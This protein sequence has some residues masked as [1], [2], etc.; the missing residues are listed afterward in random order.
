MA[1]YFVC[2]SYESTVQHLPTFNDRSRHVVVMEPSRRV[3]ASRRPCSTTQ[4][5]D[6]QCQTAKIFKSFAHPL[7]L[8]CVCCSLWVFQALDLEPLSP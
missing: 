5:P 7:A 4:L 8:S 6:S 1:D 2:G 3:R